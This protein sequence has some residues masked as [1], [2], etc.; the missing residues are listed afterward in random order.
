[1]KSNGSSTVTEDVFQRL[2]GPGFDAEMTREPSINPL[3]GAHPGIDFSGFNRHKV[4]LRNLGSFGE[5]RLRDPKI[6]S[7]KANPI[8]WLEIVILW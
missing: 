1:L 2:L 5:F 7:E 6:I 8:L 3:K 4:G